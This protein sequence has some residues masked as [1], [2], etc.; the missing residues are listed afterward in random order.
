MGSASAQLAPPRLVADYSTFL[1]TISDAFYDSV[2]AVATDSNGNVYVAGVTQFDLNMLGETGFPTTPGSFRLRHPRTP[3]SDSCGY[4]CGFILKLNSSNELVYGAL[5]FGMDIKALAVDANGNAHVTGRTLTSTD[6]PATPGVFSND[7]IGQAFAVKLNAQGSALVYAALFRGTEGRAIAVDSA[8]NAYVTGE[9]DQ[10]GLPTTLDALKPNYQATGDRL[11]VD[12]FL[13]K[14][15]PTGGALEFGTYLGG[16][17]LDTPAGITLSADDE[18]IVVGKSSS[19]DFVGLTASSVGE[20]DAFIVQVAADGSEIVAGKF[21]GGSGDDAANGV[22]GDGHG[23]YLVAGATHSPDFPTT[24]GTLQRRLLGTRNGWLARLDA[25]LG[26]RYSTYFGGSFIDG[27]L[28]VAGDAEGRAY[29][30]GTAFSSDLLT[31]PNGYQDV[32]TSFV[33]TLLAG[34]GSRFYPM[35]HYAVR[36]AHFGVFSPEGTSLEYGTYL[37]GYY[38][39]PRGYAPLVFGAAIARTPAGSVYVAG[40]SDA[41]SFPTLNGGLGDHMKGGSDGFLTRFVPRDLS[42]TSPTLLPAPSVGEP[43]TYQLEAAGGSPP[44][45]WELAGF[46]LPLGLQL[47]ADGQITGIAAN[48]QSENWGH[49][50]SVKVTDSTGLSATKSIFIV[51]QWPGNP[52]CS[53]NK[54]A[55]SLLKDQQFAYEPPFLA[56]GVP[57]F[58]LFIS[59]TL[60]PGIDWLEDS[61]TFGG[62]VR[63]PGNY[64][65]SLRMVDSIG[66]EGTIDWQIEVRDPNPPPVQPPAPPPSPPVANPPPPSSNGGGGGGDLTL[67]DLLALLALASVLRFRRVNS[68]G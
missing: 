46:H 32:S 64:S 67:I 29:T 18:V 65:F 19:N 63:T 44:Y 3:D 41:A 9:I 39:V 8:G 23:G 16:T 25:D 11:N 12:A 21:L 38:T 6:F 58:T 61:A 37:G 34:I 7:P 66:A 28:G 50:F 2:R 22:A 13:I 49:Q 59:G 4:P 24:A 60:P 62:H 43:F 42:V 15:D 40:S 45:R 17:G 48:P 33:G 68:V 51:M 53:P 10:A 5:L 20:A 14:I 54:C 56:R 30:I 55:L 57:P 47:G 27:F 36:E 1:G 35:A 52:Y 31:T 26:T